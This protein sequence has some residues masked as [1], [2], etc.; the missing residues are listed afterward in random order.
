MSHAQF[1]Y[2]FCGGLT[3]KEAITDPLP[4]HRLF[5]VEFSCSIVVKSWMLWLTLHGKVNYSSSVA[6]FFVLVNVVYVGTGS[7]NKI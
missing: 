1:C 7:N 5:W 4:K 3:P 2:S 6:N